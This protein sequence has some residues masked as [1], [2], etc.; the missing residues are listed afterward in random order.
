MH[1]VH[2][3]VPVAVLLSLMSTPR[4]LQATPSSPSLFLPA[5]QHGPAGGNPLDAMQELL[6][7]E[8]APPGAS[9]LH[10]AVGSGDVEQVRQVLAESPGLINQQHSRG[11][12][13]PLHEA[14]DDGHTE[15]VQVLIDAGADLN[16]QRFDGRTPLHMA[17]SRGSIDIVKALLAA[18]AYI[19]PVDYDYITPLHIAVSLGHTEIVELLL[20]EG[21]SLH[22]RQRHDVTPLHVAASSGW[23]DVAEI[24]VRHADF[25][26]HFSAYFW[27]SYLQSPAVPPNIEEAWG[28]RHDELPY[29]YR[30][31]SRRFVSA[32]V[33]V[34][35][36]YG[37]S[38]LYRSVYSGH[39]EIAELLIQAGADLNAQ[40]KVGNTALHGAAL[41]G[42][43]QAAQVLIQ[44]GADVN[45][46][47]DKGQTPL[48][49]AH[50]QQHSRLVAVLAAA[51]GERGGQELSDEEKGG[52]DD[53]AAD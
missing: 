14:V 8:S 52:Q 44:A 42:R 4:A 46:S 3:V 49:L 53:Q 34:Q 35:D 38:A 11:N 24:L 50:E 15:I 21:A 32:F 1:K 33:S 26:Y 43:A 10:W 37:H 23:L 6:A 40:D 47:N 13:A 27:P 22:A 7:I 20:R 45:I 30:Y 17:V 16:N 5:P 19:D 12:L 31:N 36:H 48:D 25:N 51:G 41:Q 2:H 18:G 29:M 28:I 9:M 39:A